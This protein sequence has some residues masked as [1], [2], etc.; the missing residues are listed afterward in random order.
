MQQR[1]VVR[2]EK[3]PPNIEG[4]GEVTIRDLV[5]NSLAYAPGS[6]HRR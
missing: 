4:K 1:H 2:L 3:R 5:I 6:H